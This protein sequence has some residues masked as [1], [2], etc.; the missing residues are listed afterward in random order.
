MTAATCG[1]RAAALAE[2]IQRAGEGLF[3][4]DAVLD[5]RRSQRHEADAL[6]LPPDPHA[7]RGLGELLVESGMAGRRVHALTSRASGPVS[8]LIIHVAFGG[9][10][11]Q[12]AATEGWS[13]PA[14]EPS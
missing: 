3:D 2:D 6:A 9:R 10:P 14:V 5:G 12:K 8:C 4:V 7:E 13:I 1:S 11:S